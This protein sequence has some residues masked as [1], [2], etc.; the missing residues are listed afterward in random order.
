MS[1]WGAVVIIV[2]TAGNIIY[3]W[4]HPRGCVVRAR[5]VVIHVGGH[6]SFLKNCMY[7]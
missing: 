3:I 1:I 5:E 6:E 4:I 7:R 2:C